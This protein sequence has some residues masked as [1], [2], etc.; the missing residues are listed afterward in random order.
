MSRTRVTVERLLATLREENLIAAGVDPSAPEAQAPQPWYIRAMVGF[1]AWLASLLLIGFIVGLSVA[2]SGGYTVIGL[3]LIVGAVAVRRQTDN[4][5]LGQGAMAC[6]LAGQALVAFGIA[7]SF[8]HDGF[9]A[10]LAVGMVMSGILF[11]IYPDRVHRVIMVLIAT[12]E[13]ASLVY[14]REANVLIPFLGPLLAGLLLGLHLRQPALMTSPFA[15]LVPPLMTGL[16]LAAFG[17]LMLSTVYLLPDLNVDI[18]F[19]PY[20]WI[21]TLLLGLLLLTFCHRL[22]PEIAGPDSVRTRPLLYAGLA[23]IVACA[24]YVPGLILGLMVVMMGVHA[25]RITFIGAGIGFFALF[26]AAFFYG[27][28]VSLLTKSYTLVATGL[29]L[30]GFRRLFLRVVSQ[31][32]SA[33]AADV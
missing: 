18:V 5:F 32:G 29:A 14:V 4:D 30:L 23:V 15:S 20:P 9:E 25:G 3:V 1:G 26:L 22:W 16:M 19:Y 27:I 2:A 21:S 12:A 24:W 10:F 28:E 8:S 13:A 11:Y 17:L 31:A 6:S 33:G 7:D